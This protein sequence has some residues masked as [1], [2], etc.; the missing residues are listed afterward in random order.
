MGELNNKEP[1]SYIFLPNSPIFSPNFRRNIF[2]NKKIYIDAVDD[3]KLADI[4]EVFDYQIKN[5][6][7]PTFSSS[8]NAF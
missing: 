2:L 8:T 6:G 1:Y 3:D 5:D 7:N 4:P